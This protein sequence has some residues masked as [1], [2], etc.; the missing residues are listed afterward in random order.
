LRVSG[1][2]QLSQFAPRHEINNAGTKQ[3]AKNKAMKAQHENR[4]LFQRMR[5]T[6]D[7]AMPSFSTRTET[8]A[9]KIM[10]ASIRK[11]GRDM[12]EIAK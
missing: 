2:V 9:D 11:K 12:R 8:T 6:E 1:S 7:R 10:L 5:E 4:K 3:L